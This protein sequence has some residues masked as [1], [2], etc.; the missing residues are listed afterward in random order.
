M[1]KLQKYAWIL[2]IL[3]GLGVVVFLAHRWVMGETDLPFQ[4]IGGLGGALLVA[5]LAL[6]RK[7]VGEAATARSTVYGSGAALMVALGLGI[8]VAVNIL[9]RRYDE[10][11]DWTATGVHTLSEQSIQTAAGL[12]EPIQVVAFFPMA[13]VEEDSFQDLYESYDAHT[14]QLDLVLYDASTEPMLAEQWDITSPYGTVILVQGERKQRLENEFGEEAFTNALINL[15]S[16]TEHVVCFTE[17]HGE[18][19]VD[20]DY[21]NEGFGAIVVKLEGTNYQVQT[22]VP[23]TSGRVP[24]ECATVVVAGPQL[25]FLPSEREIL[26]RHVLAG[27]SMTVLLDPLAAPELAADMAR[28]GIRVGDDV[29]IEDNPELLLQGMDPS[30]ILATAESFD[31]HPLTTG[32]NMTVFRLMRSVGQIEGTEGVQLQVLARSSD[33]S[34]AETDILGGDPLPGEGEL[35]VGPDG[36]LVGRVALATAAEIVDPSKI[37]VTGS[38]ALPGSFLEELGVKV[39]DGADAAPG[40]LDEPTRVPGGRVVVIG[41]ADFASNALMLN[42]NNQDL[43]LNDLAWLVGEED[44][45][46][47]RSNEAGKGTLTMSAVQFALAILITLLFVPGLAILGA[48]LVWMRRRKL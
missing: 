9:A 18:R 48:I 4:I 7:N 25:D 5:Y 2:G 38:P 13:S 35:G 41:D 47:I 45:I 46:A 31:H 3:G 30:Y 39:E 27:G 26:A 40:V 29:V 8:T 33:R 24:E 22:F 21:E 42:G 20:D 12:S 19:G 43:L 17:G 23:A 6:D 15:T 16:G 11:W 36:Q 10:R 28:Y 32:L 37:Q 44:Q 14:D 1:E 34:Y